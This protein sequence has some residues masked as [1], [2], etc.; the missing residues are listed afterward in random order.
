MVGA[1][2]CELLCGVLEQHIR[3][4]LVC[5]EILCAMWMLAKDYDENRIRF[6]AAGACVHVLS[7]MKVHCPNA[8]N[9][10]ISPPIAISSPKS[11]TRGGGGGYT[12]F[13]GSPLVSPP[14]S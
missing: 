9:G 14:N 12:R 3:N 13:L 1:G 11:T 4:N 10:R 8:L 2:V 5:E 6:G 7:A